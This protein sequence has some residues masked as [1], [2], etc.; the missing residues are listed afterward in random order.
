MSG[1]GGICQRVGDFVNE[2]GRDGNEKWQRVGGER[3]RFPF[4]RTS[5]HVYYNTHHIVSAGDPSAEAAGRRLG[6]ISTTNVGYVGLFL[7]PISGVLMDTL[8]IGVILAANGVAMLLVA[9]P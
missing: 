2:L 7:G 8:G 4:P 6:E 9:M 1:E 5:S 3:Q